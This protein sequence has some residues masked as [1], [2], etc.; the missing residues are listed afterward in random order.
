MT[1]EPLTYRL[2]AKVL[3]WFLLALAACALLGG[4]AGIFLAWETGCYT[5]APHE[6]EES[7]F[8]DML[9][10]AGN[11]LVFWISQ[12]DRE[13]AA[14]QTNLKNPEYRV[15]DHTGAEVW[16]SDGFGTAAA[17]T[18]WYFRFAYRLV[19]EA[20][21][22]GQYVHMDYLREYDLSP[23]KLAPGDYVLEAELT[24]LERSD[25]YYWTARLLELLWELR[26]AVY[27]IALLA[28][29]LLLACFV[30]LLCGAGHRSGRTELVPGYL[31][32]VPFDLMTAAL[33]AWGCAVAAA[34]D[35]LINHS[36]PDAG[37]VLLL[38]AAVLCIL[39]PFTGWCTS[40]AMRLKLG[41]WWQNTAL[42]FLLRLAGRL[43]RGLWRGVRALARGLWE[44]LRGLPLIW[45]TLLGLCA[46]LVLELTALLLTH[47][48]FDNLMLCW[49]LSRFCL[50]I[51]GVLYTALCLRRLQRSGAALAAGDMGYQT[52]TRHML[53]D[54]QKHGENLNSIGAAMTKAVE[55]RLKSER[56]KT[57]LITNVSHDIKTP[58]TSIISYVDLLKK[59]PAPEKA[60]EYLAVLERQSRRLKK[61]TEDLVEVS[62]ASTGNM[63]V[64]ASRH[65]V[66][67]LL[68]Q[69]LGEYSERLE[70]AGLETVLTLPGQEVYAFVD[71]GLT[72]RILDNLF[73]NVCKYGQRGT[74]FYVDVSRR[75]E[76]V[77]LRFRNISRAAL[78][79][80]AEE[81]MERFV[82]GDSA[83]SGEGNGLGLNI[84]R[85]LTE[86]MGGSFSLQVDGD[87][88]KV[89]V[90]LPAVAET[91][92]FVAPEATP[93]GTESSIM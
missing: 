1:R 60:R 30:F 32:T 22:G 74:R 26:Y 19:Q 45:K 83:R 6:L 11:N 40:L 80:P 39:L 52:D 36:G 43:C 13:T 82:R 35:E 8:R 14:Q 92:A 7:A 2:W 64:N 16:R 67:E 89:E 17:E 75:A 65:S 28:L 76:G 73:S 93:A 69:A 66:S 3:A 78:N 70:D 34:A 90:R 5:A 42:C 23:E 72:W 85:S 24:N 62:K 81:L 20:L 77:L 37:K 58:L 12:G 88:F 56:L 25:E 15:T 48:E 63:E 38:F 29:V 46:A 21:P 57:E 50:V 18:G 71:G 47:Y 27:G 10:S 33:I 79:L 84:A 31:W 4:G 51:P 68:R 41:R 55:E 9:R 54:F 59:D 49:L 61:L 53:R 91:S 44:L 86:L 87:L